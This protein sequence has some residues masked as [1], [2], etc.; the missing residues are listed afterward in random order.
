[1]NP[2]T[3]RRFLKVSSVT[4]AALATGGALLM[5]G[6]GDAHYRS[7]VTAETPRVL[8]LKE[9]GVLS[10]FCDRVCPEPGGKHPGPRVLRIAERI[11]R[12]LSFHVAKMQADVKAALL[13]LEHGGVL[14]LS[15]TRFTRLGPGEQTRYLERMAV[16][17]STVERQVISNLKLLTLFF[18]YCDERTWSAMHYE[19][20]PMPRKAPEAD[21]RV[22]A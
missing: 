2:L 1:M 7:L 17:G 10:V 6:G 16:D 4:A 21:S 14:H 18:Y 11:D 22:S 13:V 5:R 19:G 8:S 20:P 9:L 12:E 15:P 3:R